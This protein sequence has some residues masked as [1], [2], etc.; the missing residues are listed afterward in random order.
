MRRFFSGLKEFDRKA[1]YENLGFI[2]S[3]QQRKPKILKN[4][5]NA[6][7]AMNGILQIGN[8]IFIALRF[9]ND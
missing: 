3:D 4:N 1:S 5:E 6:K 9:L 8:S 2:R 7:N